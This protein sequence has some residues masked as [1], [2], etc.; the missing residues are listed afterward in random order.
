MP[1]LRV[2][3]DVGGTFTDICIL[4]EERGT[5]DV[6]KVPSTVDPI[7]AVVSG[8]VE[9]GIDLRD[10]VVFS[11]GTTVATNALI[12]RNLPPAAMVTTRNFRDVS[13]IR[14]GT[15]DD[16]WDA[17]KDVAPPYIRR[18]DR[19]EV[20]ERIDF[21][22]EVV[23]ALDEDDARRL[24][25]VL[26]KRDVQTIAVC[27]INSYA[28]PAHEL[29]MREILEEELPGV[30]ISTSA[31]VLPEIFEHERFSTTVANAVLSPLIGGYVRR[32]SDR[33]SEHGYEN[34]VL[35]LHS[36]GG[37]MTPK[38]AERLAVRLAASG[39]AAGAIASRHIATLCGFPN[40]IGFDMG[41][42]STDISLVYGGEERV[43]KE[44]FVEYGYPIVF[45]SIEVLTIGAGGGSFA[46][47][48]EAGSL[49]NGPQS[50]GAVPGPACYGRGN[51]RPTNTDAN[52]VLGRLGSELIGGAMT[53]DRDAA[54]RAITQHIGVPLGLEPEEAADAIIKVAN[55]N[56]ADAV[57]LIS[58]R[59]GYDPRE[60]CLVAF[61]GAGPLHGAAL[62][63]ELAIPTV[64]VPPNP[65]ITSA[66]G[67]LLVDVR[68]D[69]ATMF[70]GQVETVDRDQLEDEFGKLEREAHERLEAEDVPEE[71]MSI[72]RLIDMRYL[73]QWRSLTISVDAPVDLEAAV[74]RFHAEHQREYN[75]SRE[76]APVEI[77][78]LNVRAV[79]VTP[80]PNLKARGSS[81]AVAP[82][83][84]GTRLVHF[85][86]LDEP[87]ET[88]VYLRT[89]R[90]VGTWLMGP[91][92]IEQLDSTTV[93]PPG[94]RA[95]VDEWLNIR[96]QDEEPPA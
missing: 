57:R 1:D 20:T 7:D 34:D 41:G 72:Q 62:A 27:F 79:G 88:P 52:V 56:M 85:D 28:N 6:A 53:L 54:A 66:L 14:R 15:K 22:G 18:R 70:L 74:A 77:Y 17:Y 83:P 38:T 64:L 3:V 73:G 90:Q 50:A 16:L 30:S 36:G 5:I 44:W 47:I 80:K 84:Q 49:R 26:R 60:F 89:E 43:T 42:T 63:K 55:A 25:A 58:I 40:A 33:L 94:W 91:A 4:D 29:R 19:F 92:I 31:E 32:L 59:R 24:A 11:H 61:G 46:W 39:I 75:Y 2:A 21:A 96:M 95:E 45:P 68:H 23:T 37:V 35:L 78:R 12:T 86:E 9:A 69:L 65:G 93:V 71:Q 76:G 10:V 51:D 48:D 13:E 82:G 67:C 81:G 87:A 8:V